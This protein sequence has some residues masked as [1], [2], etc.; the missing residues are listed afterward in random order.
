MKYKHENDLTVEQLIKVYEESEEIVGDV[1]ELPG[2]QE[3][4]DP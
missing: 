2:A 3:N 4:I 1:K